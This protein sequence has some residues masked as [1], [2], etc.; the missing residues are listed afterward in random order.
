MQL[1]LEAGSA[2]G[3]D[4]KTTAMPSRSDNQPRVSL[5]AWVFPLLLSILIVFVT[6]LG[7]SL[8]WVG[9]MGSNQNH[10]VEALK[11]VK[12]EVQQ[13]RSENQQLRDQVISLAASQSAGRR[14]K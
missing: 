6:N 3:A 2:L 4:S 12:Q 5:P 11:E 9:Q 8:I 14:S 1:A 7:Y 10:L 13:L